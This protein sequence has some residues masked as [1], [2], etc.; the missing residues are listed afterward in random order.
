VAP[1]AAHDRLVTLGCRV[2]QTMTTVTQVATARVL[3]VVTVLWAGTMDA[4]SPPLVCSYKGN[5]ATDVQEHGAV[6]PSV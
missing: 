6:E 4:V 2:R 3:L 1:S 5:S